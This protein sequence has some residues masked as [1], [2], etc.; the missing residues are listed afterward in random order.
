MSLCPV[1][2][3]FVAVI[4][5]AVRSHVVA[6]FSPR[7]ELV[8]PR[9]GPGT[10]APPTLAL[11]IRLLCEPLGRPTLARHQFVKQLVRRDVSEVQIGRQAAARV[12][13][14]LVRN[15][16]IVRKMLVEKLLQIASEPL[17]TRR[18]N[19]Q[20]PPSDR[21]AAP[22]VQPDCPTAASWKLM[23]TAE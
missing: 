14:R 20:L 18:D 3:R 4:V 9:F 22:R 2:Q 16:S 17:S 10:R 11:S 1:G 8:E 13:I 5:V 21:S 6:E 23:A 12:V 7:D 15:S 19:R